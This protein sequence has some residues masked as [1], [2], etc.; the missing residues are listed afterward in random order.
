MSE[1]AVITANVARMAASVPGRV[2]QLAVSENARVAKGDLL[3]ALDPDFYRLQVEQAKAGVNVAIA[4]LDTRG[5]SVSAESSNAVIAGE[6][7]QRARVNLAQATQ[8]LDRL[9]R[10]EPKGYVTTQQ[11]EDART[12][13]LNAEASVKEA[14]AQVGAAKVLVGTT[15]GATA[16]VEQSRVALAIAERQLRESEVHAPNDGLVAGLS[17]A[18]GDYLIPGQSAFTLIDTTRWYASADFLETELAA[19]KPGD[20][21]TVYVAADRS[22]PIPG[23]V[24][25]V[26]WGVASDVQ[27]PI[28]RSLPYV[29]KSLNWVRVGQRFPVR[30][31][32]KEPPADLMRMGAS[33][34]V[35]VRH[36]S[37]C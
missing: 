34:T 21:V 11:V 33:A 31:L 12:L 32:L 13:K 17:V 2:V 10:L 5:R 30:V 35:I 29:P 1:D 26:S 22:R 4:A 16:A 15:G 6:Q 28:P 7:L 37:K 14:Q 36:D 9:V 19:I 23:V 8:T 18:Q 24:D 25:S 27:F 3:F 20:C